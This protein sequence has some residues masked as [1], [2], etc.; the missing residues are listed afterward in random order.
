MPGVTSGAG[1]PL[2]VGRAPGTTP[3]DGGD[4]MGDGIGEGTGAPGVGGGEAP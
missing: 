1:N 2:G 3:D 4:A